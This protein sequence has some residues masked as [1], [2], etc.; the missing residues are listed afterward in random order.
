MLPTRT[1]ACSIPDSECSITHQWAA[2][3]DGAGDRDRTGD[4]QLGK[5]ALPSALLIKDIKNQQFSHILNDLSGMTVGE[6][7]ALTASFAYPIPPF[8]ERWTVWTVRG[9]I[10]GR[11][12]LRARMSGLD[13]PWSGRRG[14]NPQPTAWEAATLPLSY[15]RIRAIIPFALTGFLRQH[16]YLCARYQMI[17][18]R[19]NQAT[20]ALL[21]EFCAKD[22]LGDCQAMSEIDDNRDE[23]I[24]LQ[25]RSD[26]RRS[27][28]ISDKLTT[29][30]NLLPMYF[31]KALPDTFVASSRR[32][33][34]GRPVHQW[35]LRTQVPPLREFLES[36]RSNFPT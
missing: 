28:E 5:L 11:L 25:S 20:R 10:D 35:P 27:H 22:S 7:S 19:L 34:V 15:S 36:L 12:E 14:S 3:A 1:G 26:F 24:R 18:P 32:H 2:K 30:A 6:Q 31:N 29:V 4:I 23:I 16:G 8:R 13:K 9:L 17:K 21:R 33:G